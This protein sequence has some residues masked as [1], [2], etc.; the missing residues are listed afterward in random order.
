MYNC[1][2]CN[3]EYTTYKGLAT[4]NSRTHKIST[5]QT[6]VDF[7]YNGIHPA[8]NCGCGE[9]LNYQ[10][11]KFGE[12]I[13]G[14]M[15]RVNGGFYTQEGLNKSADKRREQYAS[16]ERT[17]WNKG[18]K[19]TDEEMVK[20]IEIARS[21]ERR[22]KIS[23]ALKGIKKSP[24]HIAKI[25]ADRKI[26]WGNPVHREEQRDRRMNHIL[27]NGMCF[28]SKLEM[29]FKEIME[30]LDIKYIEQFYVRDIKALYDFKISGTKILIEVDGDY[31][32]CNPNIEKFRL[33]TR[34][35][36]HDNLKR[37]II[38]NEWASNNGYKLLRFWEYDIM[39]NRSD[40]VQRLLENIQ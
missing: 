23:N 3:T 31:W 32:H 9:K 37:D 28:T 20:V 13:R 10:N 21:P 15:S 14:H 1:N 7:Y 11:G 17:Q 34:Q 25:T 19:Y 4:H 26:Y 5:T 38:K 36:H 39:N 24:E 29:V 27:N 30:S 16:G 40:V 12:Y 2:I 22:L 35:W 18:R 6:Y 33:P 8:C